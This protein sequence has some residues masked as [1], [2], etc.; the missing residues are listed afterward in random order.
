[1]K[2]AMSLLIGCLFFLTVLYPAGVLLC[3]GTDYSFRLVS[4]P[5][6]AVVIAVLSVCAVSFNIL[7]KIKGENKLIGV[8]LAIATPLPLINGLLYVLASRQILVL[9]CVLICAACWCDLA[10]P[11]AKPFVLKV[12]SFI[13]SALMVLPMIA[14]CAIALVVDPFGQNTVIK[15]V[16]SPSSIY[17]AQVIDSD[18]GILGADTFVE[19]YQ[20][21]KFDLILFKIEKKPERVYS[22]EYGEYETMKIYWKNDACL[23]IN[24]VEYKMT[25]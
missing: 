25:D 19:V 1:M 11:Q 10:A 8:L 18:Q 20:K 12:L 15:T 2:K 23:V 21:S 24:G 13:L 4:V 3:I 14:L 6:F 5:A 16:E 9:I 7:F 17:C 22:G